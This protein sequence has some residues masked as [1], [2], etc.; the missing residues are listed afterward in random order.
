MDPAYAY[1]DKLI[2]LPYLHMGVKIKLA[3]NRGRPSLI[4]T[5][6]VFHYPAGFQ[7]P[8][9]FHRPQEGC[10]RSKAPDPYHL[11]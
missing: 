5:E 3:A 1:K 6:S 8:A 9:G 2:L 7:Y 10:G 11:F 4:E